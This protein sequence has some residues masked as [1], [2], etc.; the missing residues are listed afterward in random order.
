M[1]VMLIEDAEKSGIQAVLDGTNAD[2][3]QDYRPGIRALKELG[4]LSP[5]LMHEMTKEDI[6]SISKEIGLPLWNR[7]FSACLLSRMPYN[8]EIT[9]HRLQMIEKSEQY[10]KDMGFTFVRVRSDG[11]AAR[12]EV[13]REERRKLFDDEFLDTVSKT[14]KDMGFL[15]VS[16]E[17]EGYRTGSMNRA[18]P[19]KDA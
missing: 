12:I 10:L 11:T 15:Y 18:L 14:L 3:L 9:P 16:F 6:R 4:V 7:G 1:L 19:I 13:G 17:L 5:F 8:H 2:D